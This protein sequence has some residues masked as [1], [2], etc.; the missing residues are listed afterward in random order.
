[1]GLPADEY[2][3]MRV[4]GSVKKDG[5]EN[6]EGRWVEIYYETVEGELGECTCKRRY[7]RY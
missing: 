1:M 3:L 5:G 4:S 7:K 6:P 2:G